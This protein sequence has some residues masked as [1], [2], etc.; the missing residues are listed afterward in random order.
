MPTS[1]HPNHVLALDL[2]GG[3]RLAPEASCRVTSFGQLGVQDLHRHRLLELEVES[4]ENE[5]H[6]ALAE[7][8]VDAVLAGEDPFS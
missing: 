3:S 2:G 1:E 5:P 4:R 8:A 7:N 6:S